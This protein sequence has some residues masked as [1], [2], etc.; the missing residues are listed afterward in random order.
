VDQPVWLDGSYTLRPVMGAI[1]EAEPLLVAAGGRNRD[2]HR[3]V[4]GRAAAHSDGDRAERVDP[5]PQP[6]RQQLFQLRERPYR[7]LLD[8][9]DRAVGGR[10]KP[11]NHRD[12]LVVVEQ[13]R[14]QRGPDAQ[15][16]T[17]DARARLHRVPEPAQPIH[18]P[19]QRPPGDAQPLG[20]LGTGQLAPALQQG[21]QPQ[22]PSGRLPHRA[23]LQDS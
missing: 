20:Q 13:Q 4:D 11:E 14:R 5:V 21:Q 19:P 6:R 7:R 10:P 15:P 12:R 18:V 1:T 3:R 17:G 2:Q 16:V 23:I 8:P 9:R 22:Q